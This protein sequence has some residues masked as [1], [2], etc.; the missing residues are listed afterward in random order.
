M[1][2]TEYAKADPLYAY[3]ALSLLTGARAE[4]AAA[5]PA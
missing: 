1:N 4:E 5:L 2:V 3:V